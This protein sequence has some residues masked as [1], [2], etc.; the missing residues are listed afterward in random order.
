[1]TTLHAPVRMGYV[2]CGFMAQMVH[3]PNIWGLRETELVALAEPRAALLDAVA[4]R[5]GVARR[6]DSHRGLADDPEIEAVMVSGHYSG[7][8]EIAAELLAAGKHVL[9]EK[10]M[11]T[12]VEQAERILRAE[13]AGDA[14]LMVGYMKRY[15]AG[16]RL[17]KALL[18][19][20]AMHER[21]GEIRHIRY[22]S[23]DGGEWL[24]GIDNPHTTSEEPVPASPEILPGWLAAENA[25]RYLLYLQQY[26]HNVNMLRWLFDAGDAITVEHVDLDSDGYTGVVIFRV[27]GHRAVLETGMAETHDFDEQLQIYCERGWLRTSAAPLLQRN[28][29]VSV[30]VSSTGPRGGEVTDLTPAEWTWAYR[31]EVSHFAQALREGRPFDS[32]GT[33]AL[34][35]VRVFEDLFRRFQEQSGSRLA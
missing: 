25:E 16:Y 29:P 22:H 19:D 32:P 26:T 35:D 15:D 30:T 33:D 27:G 21:L 8:G 13:A 34:H 4:A 9:V 31:E 18:S 11:A 17:V 3:I 2:G 14:R 6:Y 1:M 24:A 12:T 5:Y 7:Q 28:Q 10:P 23:F 20:P